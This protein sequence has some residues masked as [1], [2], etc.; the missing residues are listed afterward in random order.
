MMQIIKPGTNIDFV[1]RRKIAYAVSVILI[2]G[3]I[4]SL[5]VHGG[6]KQG[7]DFKGGAEMIVNFVPPVPIADVKAVFQLDGVG[8][9]GPKVRR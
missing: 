9:N 5:I 8:C 7:I 6:P 2:I 4:I 3:S 1:G